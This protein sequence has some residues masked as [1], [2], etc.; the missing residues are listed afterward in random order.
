MGDFP[1]HIFRAYDIRGVFGK[2]L[3]PEIMLDI[4]L[5]LGTMMKRKEMGNEIVIG[6]DIRMSS[7][8]LS[9]ALVSGLRSSGINVTDVGTV[10][11]G[12]CFFSGWKLKSGV[13]A[14]VTASHLGPEWNGLKMRTGEG[15][16]FTEENNR[17]IGR[18][19]RDKEFEITPEKTGNYRTYDMKED[20]AEF[21]NGRFKINKKLKVVVDCGNGSMCISAPKILEK[22]G[23]EVVRLF[24][25]IDSNFPNR[26]S[27]PTPQNIRSLVAKV[28]EEKA[29]FGI[30]FDGDGDRA[31]LVDDKGRVLTGNENGLIIGRNILEKKKGKIIVTVACSMSFER[32]LQP[33]GAEIVRIQVG[34]TYVVAE[35]KKQKAILGVEESNHMVMPD[36]F[37]FDDSMLIP[38]KI[39]EIICASGKRLSDIIGEFRLYPFEEV[40]FKCPEKDKF[41]VVENI[42]KRLSAKYEKANTIDGIRI[43]FEDGWALMRAANTSPKIRLSIESESDE[44]LKKLKEEFS[45]IVEDEIKAVSG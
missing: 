35:C 31:A 26:P 3:T 43:E 22:L 30:A 14:F 45:K 1:S 21:L 15:I 17:E 16:S 28:L 34:D 39:S 19:V 27:E 5:A 36:Y 25:D 40:V 4:G 37:A 2:D 10:P 20:Y 6:N 18:M 7:E 44:G 9:H 32:Q 29:D 12:V 41:K 13:T 33:L 42:Q 8:A 11:F 38:L 23:F 24:C